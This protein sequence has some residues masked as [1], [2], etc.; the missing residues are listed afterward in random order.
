MTTGRRGRRAG[1]RR[2]D[3]I[4]GA[5]SVRERR[6]PANLSDHLLLVARRRVKEAGRPMIVCQACTIAECFCPVV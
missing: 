1:R 3:R 4:D 2:G 6:E 5:L